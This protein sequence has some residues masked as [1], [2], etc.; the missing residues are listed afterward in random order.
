[1]TR[2]N[3][4]HTFPVSE[5]AE[6]SHAPLSMGIDNHQGFNLVQSNIFNSGKFQTRAPLSQK[7]YHQ[8]LL[9]QEKPN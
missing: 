3:S 1:M 4:L 6:N 7:L 2:N 5:R 8:T 9:T